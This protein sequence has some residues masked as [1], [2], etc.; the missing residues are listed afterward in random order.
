MTDYTAALTADVKTK[1][2]AKGEP[3]N[4]YVAALMADVKA[5]NPAEPEFHQAVQ[6]VVESLAPVLE[7]HPE[8]RH[9]RILE[10]IAQLRADHTE[11]EGNDAGA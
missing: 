8:Y 7:R 3:M 10:R 11:P 1:T 2:P 5:K 9:A 4:E 6:E